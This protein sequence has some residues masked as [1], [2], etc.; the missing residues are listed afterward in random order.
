LENSF[1][2]WRS[3]FPVGQQRFVKRG[4]VRTPSSRGKDA[5]FDIVVAMRIDVLARFQ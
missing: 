3:G 1:N 4:L 2:T 5:I